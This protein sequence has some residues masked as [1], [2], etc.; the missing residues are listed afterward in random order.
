[1]PQSL[2][3]ILIHLT[4][5]TKGR[6]AMIPSGLREDLN[7]YIVG[8]L[9]EQDCTPVQ[10]NAWEDHVHVLFAAARNKPLSRIV[11]EIKTGSSK[12]LKTRG[13]SSFHRQNGCAAFSVSKSNLDAVIKYIQNQES[14]HKKISF[15][16]ELRRFLDKN[17]MEYDERFLWD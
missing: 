7:A 17:G 8:I 5:S 11:S 15:Q 2:A 3:Q 6:A 1:M 9:R 13:C 12:W 14:H 10:V 16:D 4:F